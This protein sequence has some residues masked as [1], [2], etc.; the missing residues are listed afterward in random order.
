MN[1]LR[2]AK[3]LFR[4][5]AKETLHLPPFA[6]STLRGGFGHAFRRIAC[7]TGK[8]RCDD[9]L[10]KQVCPYGYV[11]ETSPPQDAKALRGYSKVPQPFVLEPPLEGDGTYEPG[12]LLEFG[13]VLIGRGIDY[14]PYFV[15]AFRELGRV[16][17]GRGRGKYELEEII[18]IHPLKRSQMR[19]YAATDEMIRGEDLSVRYAEVEEQAKKMPGE[20]VTIRFLTPTRIKREG[21]YVSEPE[22][23]TLVRALLRRFSSLYYFHCGESWQ[24]DYRGMIEA[25]AEVKALRLETEWVDWSRYSG[26]QKA[27]MKLGG[28]VG[29]AVYKGPLRPFLPLLL[30]GEIVHV[31]KACTFGNGKYLVV[32]KK[33]SG[34]SHLS[35]PSGGFGTG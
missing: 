18:G 14:F 30:V 2:L 31:G 17:I 25:A 27:R 23:P 34:G 32:G 15:V 4:L 11:F 6:G 24:A 10:L 7:S 26:R 20:E 13:L 8:T 28:F 21:H 19:L 1:R 3:Y 35:P 9:C 12:D 16:G 33:S 29:E 5:Q 22:F